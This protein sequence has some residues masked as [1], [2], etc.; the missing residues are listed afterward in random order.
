[1][2]L[3]G[4]SHAEHIL[5]SAERQRERDSEKY[6][7]VERRKTEGD[8]VQFPSWCKKGV[9]HAWDGPLPRLHLIWFP[10]RH[11]T[12]PEI[13]NEIKP[14]QGTGARVSLSLSQGTV[15]L[16]SVTVQQTSSANRQVGDG[17]CGVRQPR[18]R[19]RTISARQN[20]VKI[21]G[22]KKGNKSGGS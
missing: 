3:K 14:R 20:K 13:P 8:G 2:Q 19:H 15:V 4:Q 12:P 16:Q 22:E 7:R 17:C 21:K 11:S 18:A 5:G 10:E 6:E 9:C 1:M